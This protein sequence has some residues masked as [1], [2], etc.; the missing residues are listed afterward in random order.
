LGVG[1]GDIPKV[2]KVGV[3]DIP[4]VHKVGVGD[5]P[6]VHKIGV[7][8]IPKLHIALSRKIKAREQ[9]AHLGLSRKKLNG[10]KNFVI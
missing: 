8:D 6:K 9:L 7:G 1:V 2:H 5:I 4:K 3:G 10:F